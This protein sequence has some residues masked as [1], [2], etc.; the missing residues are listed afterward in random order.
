MNDKGYCELARAYCIDVVDGRV[1][2]CEWVRRSCQRQIDDLR[3]EDWRWIFDEER[4]SSICEFLEC[5]PHVKGLWPSKTIVLQPWQIFILTTIFGW[6]DKTDKTRRYRRALVVIPRKNSKSTMAAGIA[7][8]LLALDSEP[9]AEVYSAATTREQAKISWDIARKMIQRMPELRELGVEPLAHSIALVAEGACYKPLSRDADSLEGL[10]IHGAIIDEL[11]AHNNREVFDVIDEGIGSRRQPLI[12]MISTEGDA[13][14]GIFPEQ[15]DYLQNV[16]RGARE[17]D[18]YFGVIYTIDKSDDWTQRASWAK[19]NPNFGVSVYEDDLVARFAQAKSNPES[20]SSFLTKRL[21]VRVGAGEA[22]FNM[23]SWTALCATPNLKMEDF[24]G[25]SSIFTFDLASKSDVAAR[26]AVFRKQGHF[27]VFGKYYLPEDA[28]ERGH[29]NYDIYR[30]WASADPPAITFTPGKIIDYEF[31][32]EDLLRDAKEYRIDLIGTDPYNATQFQTNMTARGLKM[33]DLFQTTLNLSEPMKETAALIVSGRIHHNGDPVLTWMI[34]NVVAKRDVN[35][36]VFP[37]K[38][39][40]HN[41]IDGA[42]ALIG[43]M[44]LQMRNIRIKPSLYANKETA[45]I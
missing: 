22:Y 12:F 17:D 31:I 16:L 23:L 18:R 43:N 14:V 25:Q 32:Q 39:R 37:R 35:E 38:A 13:S 24:R 44:S 27:Y 41:K 3:R 26:I 45:R 28:L 7:L 21:G 33:I 34:G 2:A 29:P 40:E 5:L 4:A 20:Q 11:H 9:G 36:N 6:I 30:G 10:N 1:D 8:F 15:V 42:V 19:A